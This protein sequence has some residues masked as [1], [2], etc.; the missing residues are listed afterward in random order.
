MKLQTS[1]M[2]K[3]YNY[4]DKGLIYLSDEQL[5]QVQSELWKMF[6]EIA[7]VCDKHEIAYGF[8]GGS[9]I[10]TLRHHG[11]LP[12]DDDLDIF[13]PR[14]DFNRLE[15]VFECE[16]GEKYWL[17]TPQNHDGYRILLCRIRKK[18][19]V[20]RLRDDLDEEE[21]GLF[22]DIFVLENTYNNGLLRKMHG[23]FSYVFGFLFSCRKYKEDKK[24]LLEYVG[25]NKELVKAINFK[26]RIGSLC[27][28][29]SLNRWR[30]WADKVHR[31]CHDN[32]SKYVVS[33]AGRGLF[34]KE[35]YH[36]E[37][38]C[39]MRKEAFEDGMAQVPVGVEEHLERIYGSD[40][41]IP[42]AEHKKE[43]HILFEFDLGI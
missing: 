6:Q 34:F 1:G 15:Q 4:D 25:A 16:L 31:M 27:S 24:K 18:N 33:P 5:K 38:M 2:F 32:N 36:R 8:C 41:M 29:T 7:S 10:G 9:A 17:H 40:F 20:Y 12:W 42:P 43:V 19:T 39:K 26:S 22:V 37:N 13:M 28:F 30:K 14:E 11:F 21:A 3:D 35:T 23:F